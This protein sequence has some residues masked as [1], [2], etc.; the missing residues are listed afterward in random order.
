[1]PTFGLPEESINSRW[2]VKGSMT[3]YKA[4]LG[5]NWGWFSHPDADALAEKILAELAKLAA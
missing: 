2:F 5:S 1:M 4:P 3:R